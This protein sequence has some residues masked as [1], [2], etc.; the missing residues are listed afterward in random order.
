MGALLL[1]C[2][3]HKLK[4]TSFTFIVFICTIHFVSAA[5]AFWIN[6]TPCKPGDAG[7]ILSLTSLLGAPQTDEG[8]KSLEE[9]TALIDLSSNCKMIHF[10]PKFID[11]TLKSV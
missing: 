6:S 7:L 5:V 1:L 3:V 11:N 4:H 9:I 10:K 8:F 2:T